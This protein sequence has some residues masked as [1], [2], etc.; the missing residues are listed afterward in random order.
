MD[1]NMH[2]LDR[3]IEDA[4]KSEPLREVP[5]GF[6]R[7]VTERVRVAALANGERRGFHSRVLASVLLF[8]MIG[9][10][11]VL[12]PALAF[13]QGWTYRALPGVMGYFDYLTVL[14][15]Q[16]WGAIFVALASGAG[17]AGVAGI[18]WMVLPALRK[19]AARQH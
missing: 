7:R 13:Y 15:A 14:V 17:V 2:D 10:T 6:H 18:I 16:S 3:F 12:V 8:G 5:T 19:R 9:F 1:P 11:V 4:L